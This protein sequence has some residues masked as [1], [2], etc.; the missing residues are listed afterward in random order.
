MFLFK[1]IHEKKIIHNGGCKNSKYYS[2]NREKI[3]EHN[4]IKYTCE[5]CGKK[6]MICNKH[7][8]ICIPCVI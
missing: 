4:S 1:T 8:H 3:K 5:G 2:K 7:R 6:I